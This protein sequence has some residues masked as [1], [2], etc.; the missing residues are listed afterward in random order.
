MPFQVVLTH[1]RVAAVHAAV[2][3]IP[4]MRLNMRFDI[5]FPSKAAIAVRVRARPSAVERVRTANVRGNFFRTDAGVFD[6]GFDIK[7][8]D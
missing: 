5:F 2:L 4:E 6:S 8:G 7:V 1:E 3:S